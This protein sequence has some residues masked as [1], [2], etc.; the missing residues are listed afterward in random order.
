MY[1]NGNKD[2][3]LEII[4]EMPKTIYKKMSASH[5]ITASFIMGFPMYAAAAQQSINKGAES[6]FINMIPG[7]I[8]LAGGII[9]LVLA[10]KY[11]KGGSL[12]KPFALI[13]IGALID[14]FG[15]ILDSLATTNLIASPDYLTQIVWFASLIFR[16]SVVMGVVWI[17]NVFGVL[18]SR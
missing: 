18:R 11:M 5:I 1:P 13:G 17:A 7:W 6:A 16:F 4:Q 15:Q 3:L 14:S 10:F 2:N 12:A 9:V 8:S